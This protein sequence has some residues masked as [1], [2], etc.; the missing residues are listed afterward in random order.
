M[1]ENYITTD[2]AV[3]EIAQRLGIVSSK[4]PFH[5]GKEAFFA[6]MAI[7]EFILEILDQM[8][9]FGLIDQTDDG[10]CKKLPALV[11][12]V[13]VQYMDYSDY[14]EA[15]HP[16][17]F[18]TRIYENKNTLAKDRPCC[19]DCGVIEVE[20]RV[21]NVLLEPSVPEELPVIV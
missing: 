13:L 14:K 2:E 7:P 20:I 11:D 8:E 16:K 15:E 1:L 17:P 18:G 9:E 21:K 12:D 6:D 3:Y 4:V 5:K 10:T 19:R